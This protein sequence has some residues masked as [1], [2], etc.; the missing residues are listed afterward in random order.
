MDTY[1]PEFKVHTYINPISIL[2][3]HLTRYSYVS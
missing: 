2:E 3:T 1:L